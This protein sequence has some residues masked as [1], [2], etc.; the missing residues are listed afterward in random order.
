MKGVWL[1]AVSLVAC[2]STTSFGR[3]DWKLET[4]ASGR[5]GSLV[6][7]ADGI[8]HLTYSSLPSGVWYASKGD[9]DWQHCQVTDTTSDAPRFGLGLDPEGDPHATYATVLP[10]G[11]PTGLHYT[12]W[13]G[14]GFAEP[15]DDVKLG[16]AFGAS[17]ALALTSAGEPRIAYQDM[18]AQ[19]LW[20]ATGTWTGDEWSW[21][22]LNL[23]PDA[24]YPGSHGGSSSIALDSND[25]PGIA[26][27]YEVANLDGG[28]LDRTLGY[29]RYAPDDPRADVNGWVLEVADLDL[30]SGASACLVFDSDDLPRILH[31]DSQADAL[32]YTTWTPDSGWVSRVLDVPGAVSNACLVLD[33]QDRERIAYETSGMIQYAAWNGSSWD[34]STVAAGYNPR[35]ALD[36]QDN[37]RILFQQGY[38]SGAIVVCAVP[39]P[40]CLCM[41]AAAGFALIRRTRCGD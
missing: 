17:A 29:G 35:L 28:S 6:I 32:R 12:D 16:D 11:L 41:L 20:Y 39:E 31:V 38:G 19:D 1:T 13:R 34:I 7:A 10:N 5:P 40:T 15:H 26:Y 36:A 33:S 22:N 27:R 30:D 25:N 3:S 2:L 37:P 8:P 24:T 14:T 4:V 21:T 9:E 23:T 18:L